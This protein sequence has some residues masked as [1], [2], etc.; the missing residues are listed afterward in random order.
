MSIDQAEQ[1]RERNLQAVLSK[2]TGTPLPQYS[3]VLR[4]NSG[5]ISQAKNFAT[6]D[7][8][9]AFQNEIMIRNG[10]TTIGPPVSAKSTAASRYEALLS[11]PSL[12]LTEAAQSAE[13]RAYALKLSGQP[14]KGLFWYGVA[15]TTKGGKG[16]YEAVTFPVRPA[17]WGATI[18][19]VSAL[20]TP[21]ENESR[22][23]FNKR[24]TN[25]VDSDITDSTEKAQF[26]Q[27]LIA[28]LPTPPSH[29]KEQ[30]EMGNRY[31][32]ALVEVILSDPIG[33]A[34]ES[35]GGLLGGYIAAK[36]LSKLPSAIRK[37]T[38]KT[39]EQKAFEKL[40]PLD[41]IKA[42]N[43]PDVGGIEMAVGEMPIGESPATLMERGQWNRSGTTLTELVRLQNR[44][45][46]TTVL[47][48][49]NPT[50]NII[51]GILSLNDANKITGGIPELLTLAS[52][53]TVV[54]LIYID[55]DISNTVYAELTKINNDAKPVIPKSAYKNINDDDEILA[56]L[57][58]MG[59]VVIPDVSQIEIQDQS[60]IQ[61]VEQVQEQVQEQI[62]EQVQEQVQ[63]QL[64]E[65]ITE[66]ITEVPDPPVIPKIP[67]DKKK[68]DKEAKRYSY[69]DAIKFSVTIKYTSGSD[70]FTETAKSA[71]IAISKALT[72]RTR[73]KEIPVEVIS[74]RLPK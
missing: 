18:K 39:L 22:A 49:V 19:T 23:D 21:K 40:I 55:P 72:R 10:I 32:A 68:H 34:A 71:P 64:T 1:N 62:Q 2:T 53:L 61:L 54:P 25:I 27:Q 35:G 14:A 17:Q 36:I 12:A 43:L 47:A 28:T 57:L 38:P 59:V 42:E 31:R 24:I 16:F 46:T 50:S 29:T 48:L 33:F 65:E 4:D 7:Q 51:E 30:I 45:G 6:L 58:K 11:I 74:K 13:S 15:Q 26:A 56:S 20:L 9:K 52:G 66:Q 5:Y 3:V 70:R 37:L 73:K 63:E 67:K 41:S 44:R 69:K 60:I 8:A